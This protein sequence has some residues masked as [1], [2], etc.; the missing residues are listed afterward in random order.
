MFYPFKTKLRKTLNFTCP[1]KIL[2]SQSSFEHSQPQCIAKWCGSSYQLA[3][4]LRCCKIVFFLPFKLFSCSKWSWSHPFLPGLVFQVFFTH[5]KKGFLCSCR[6]QNW[7]ESFLAKNHQCQFFFCHSLISL[8]HSQATKRFIYGTV[9]SLRQKG[10]H[11]LL[12]KLRQEF[13]ADLFS[14]LWVLPQYRVP[15]DPC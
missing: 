9:K 13:W 8:S 2:I 10:F 11:I 15:L 14:Y 12:R 7:T 6:V 1:G 4:K 5:A 3:S